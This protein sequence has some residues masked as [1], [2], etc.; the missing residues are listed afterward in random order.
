MVIRNLQKNFENYL[1]ILKYFQ[2]TTTK[3]WFKIVG[4]ICTK[5]NEYNFKVIKISNKIFENQLWFSIS[6]IKIF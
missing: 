4:F 1:R 3:T 5:I 6:K 2:K